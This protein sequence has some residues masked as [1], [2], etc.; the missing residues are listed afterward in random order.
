M[1]GILGFV[2][3]RGGSKGIARK[4]IKALAGKP[5]IAWTIEQALKSHGLSRVIVSTEDEEI[6]HIS[7][8]WGAEVPFMRPR[9]LA[10]DNSH[11]ILAVENALQW[12]EKH[13]EW[14]PNYIM[15]LQPTSPLRTSE[16]I[17]AAIEISASLN[18]VAVVSVS[19]SDPHPYLI[20]RILKDGTMDDFM[21][22]D[23]DS[24]RR[25]D[26]P[27]A[28]VLNGA[29]YL[30]RRESILK[31]RTFLPNGTFAY[32]MPPDRSLD[33]DTPWDF[34]IADLILRDK[35]ANK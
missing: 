5:L 19:E 25:Q 16:D 3:A 23:V 10:Q 33:I 8:D 35:H 6:A 11:P 20:K 21:T 18:P 30:N 17:D 31:D 28:Y 7:R 2:P 22:I 9:E 12:L 34:Y 32:I 29:I 1:S 4:N 27:L 24:L 14:H 26:L 15:L 13:E